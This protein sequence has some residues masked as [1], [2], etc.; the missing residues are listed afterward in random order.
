[1]L[2]SWAARA[3]LGFVIFEWVVQLGWKGHGAYSYVANYV[4]DLGATQC[5]DQGNPPRYVCSPSF[6]AMD[7]ALIFIG[8]SV[9]V[10]ACLITS[11]VLWIAAHAGDLELAYRDV[12]RGEKGGKLR[13]EHTAF[14]RVTTLVIRWSLVLT[15]LAIVLIGAFPEDY[16]ST[17]HVGAVGVLLAGIVISL[18]AIGVLWFRRTN[19]SIAFFVLAI[20][21]VISAVSMV[22]YPGSDLS[23]IFERGVIYSFVAGMA[24]LGFMVSVAAHNER[25]GQLQPR[26][27]QPWAIRNADRLV[28]AFRRQGRRPPTLAPPAPA[29]GSRTRSPRGPAREPSRRP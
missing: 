26:V 22:L 23:G 1:M 21:A 28:T 27:G 8:V 29:T 16:V 4:S 3:M 13:I 10:A 7:L 25:D 9:V 5:G 20:V 17:V 15:G 6:A 11:P 12:R 18:A 24:I 19:A 14:A 2:G